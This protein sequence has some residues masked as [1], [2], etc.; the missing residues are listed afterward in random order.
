MTK[1]K[2]DIHCSICSASYEA[3]EG[4]IEV[5]PFGH[6]CSGC[7]HLLHEMVTNRKTGEESRVPVSGTKTPSAIVAHLDQYIVGQEKAKKALAIAVYNHYK[8]LANRSGVEIGKSNVLLVGPTGSGKTLL[9]QSIARFLDVPFTIAD[10]TSLTEAGYVGDDVETILQ[11]LLLAADGDVAKAEHGIVFIDEIDKIAKRGAGAS[12]TRDVSGE[13]VQQ[14][15]LKIIEGT[16]ARIPKTGSR[17]HPGAETEFMDTSNILFICS[18]AF[19][20]LR[21]AMSKRRRN[22]HAIGFSREE[23]P[24]QPGKRDIPSPE[25]F[26]E[27]GLIPEFVGR[28]PVVAELEALSP[29]QLVRI[30]TEPRNAIVRQMEEL[31]RMDGVSLVFEPQALQAIAEEAWRM[32]TGA[33]GVRA[34]LEEAL[35]EAMFSA[36]D[37]KPEVLTVDAEMLRRAGISAPATVRVVNA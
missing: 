15:L 3:V 6:I 28:L 5:S 10:A 9:A 2:K 36:P 11:R 32:G 18:G 27:F 19:V 8:R 21:E 7:I 31:F 30:M 37:E 22:T 1:P 26:Q 12:I 17:K 20:G 34:I 23:A 14:A 25:D 13:G 4:M 24:V 16:K 33:R 35:R 29:E